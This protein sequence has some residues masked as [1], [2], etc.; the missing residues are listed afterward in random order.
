MFLMPCQI[1]KGVLPRSRPIYSQCTFSLTYAIISQKPSKSQL[2]LTCTINSPSPI[3]LKHFCSSPDCPQP[4]VLLLPPPPYENQGICHHIQFFAVQVLWPTKA[5]IT[6][7]SPKY[8]RL[9]L[10]TPPHLRPSSNTM[11]YTNIPLPTWSYGLP[12]GLF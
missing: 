7:H 12:T 6:V 3:I 4:P 11:Y 9:L 1:K 10:L 5:I 8:T 2:F